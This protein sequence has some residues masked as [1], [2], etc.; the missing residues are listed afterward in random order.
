MAGGEGTRLRPLTSNQPKPMAPIV[1]KP[2]MQHIVELLRPHGFDDI[3]VTVA[4]LPQVIRGYFGDGDELGVRMQYSVEESPLGTAG[5]VRG[6]AELLDDTFLVI[7]GDALCDFDLYRTGRPPPQRGGGHDRP[8]AG[9]QPAR[10]RRRHHRRGGPDRALPGEAVLG[11]GLLGHDQHRRLRARALGAAGD[12]RERAVRLLEAALPRPP[13]ARPAPATAGS[14]RATGRTWGRWS[15]TGRP[16]TTRST[17][18]SRSNPGHPA[19]R[20]RLLGDGV[21][22]PELGQ[23]EGPAYIGNFSRIDAGARIE[24]TP[25]WATTWSS[26]TAPRPTAR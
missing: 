3:V 12:P 25:C 5:S 2:C 23:I 8:Q 4:Y 22:L 21:Q 20:E 10:V 14:P 7:S 6:A 19:A 17:A 1:G 18:R 16:T 9:R 24:S 11:P 26:R 13:G 15:S